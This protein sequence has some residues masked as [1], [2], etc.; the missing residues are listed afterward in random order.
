M[1]ALQEI[2]IDEIQIG[3]HDLQTDLGHF[4]GSV[5]PRLKQTGLGDQKEE[6]CG[7]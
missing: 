7:H 2:R 5:L 6:G 1:K 3:N 4:A